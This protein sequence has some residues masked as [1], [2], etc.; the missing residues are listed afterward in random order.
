MALVALTYARANML[1]TETWIL[2]DVGVLGVDFALRNP[3]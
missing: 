1:E 3:F 2:R